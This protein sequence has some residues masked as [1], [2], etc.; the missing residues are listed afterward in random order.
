VVLQDARNRISAYTG[1]IFLIMPVMCKDAGVGVEFF[2]TVSV[3]A[4]PNISIFVCKDALYLT[5]G[6]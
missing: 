1:R 2:K 3:G 6:Y 5:Y 4:C